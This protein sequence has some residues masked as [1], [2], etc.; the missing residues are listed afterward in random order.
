[1]RRFLET[2]DDVIYT[3][4][5]I[6][7]DLIKL[8]RKMFKSKNWTFLNADVVTSSIGSYDIILCRHM[9]MHLFAADVQRLLMKFSGSGSRYLFTTSHMTRGAN[10]ELTRVPGRFR[11]LNLELPPYS[12]SSGMCMVP[13]DRPANLFMVLYEL[14]LKQYRPCRNSSSY[15]EYIKNTIHSCTKWI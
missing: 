11:F 14:P 5:D 9:M 12:L 7:P 6:V 3:G 15:L 10:K 1:M 4:M 13:E 2:R 8:H